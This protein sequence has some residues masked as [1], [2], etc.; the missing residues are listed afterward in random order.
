MG[1]DVAAQTFVRAALRH[2]KVDEWNT[3]IL[4]FLAGDIGPEKFLELAKND[5]RKLTDAHSLIGTKCLLDG[6]R[7]SA[8]VHFKW[9]QE[10]GSH[11]R[12]SHQLA[13]TEYARMIGETQLLTPTRPRNY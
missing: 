7:K 1:K 10:H 5:E 2:A 11:E 6:D 13:R 8:S 3:T 9:D 4:R 12:I